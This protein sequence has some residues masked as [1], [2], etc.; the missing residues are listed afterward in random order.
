[1]IIEKI[2]SRRESFSGYSIDGNNVTVGGITVDLAAEERDQEVI[3]TFG[4]LNGQICR[5]L[6]PGCIYAAEIVIPPRKYNVI[7]KSGEEEAGIEAETIPVPLDIDTVTLRLWPVANEANG[8][9]NE[10]TEGHY[11]SE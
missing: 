1:M 7:E 2:D 4:N 5:G 9:I 3:I 8:E 6:M 10:T 11:G